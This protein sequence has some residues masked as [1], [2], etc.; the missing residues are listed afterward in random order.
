MDGLLALI[1]L[2]LFA[3]PL[4][5]RRKGSDDNER[6]YQLLKLTSRSFASVIEQLHP[7]MRDAVMIFYVVLRGLDTIE[8]DTGLDNNVKLPLLGSFR[9]V[10]K[11]KDWTFDDISP[12]EKDG[13]VLREFDVVLR[14]FH[15]LKS[16]YQ[17]VIADIADRMGKGMAEYA[18]KESQHN[19][20]GV[21]TIAD[22]DLY[23]HHVAGIVGE[24]LTRM[25]LIAGFADRSLAKTPQLYESM[26][27]FLQKTNIIRDYREDLDDGRSFWPQEVWKKYAK[28]LREF[29]KAENTDQ[30]LF[31]ISGL[32]VHS[33]RHVTDVLEYLSKVHDE[34]LFR[35]CAIPQV[36]SIA[37]L[38]LVFNNPQVFQKN[39][40]ISK[41]LTAELILG[42]KEMPSVY[43]IFRHFVREIHRRNNPQDP[44]FITVEKLCGKIEQYINVKDESSVEF[45]RH[46]DAMRTQNQVD[47]DFEAVMVP[48]VAVV[49]LLSVCG[50]M[51]FI[52]WLFGAQYP[53][54]LEEFY[55][56]YLFFI[57]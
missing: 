7:D 11:R 13:V 34:S 48:V 54:P 53:N 49:F 14:Q 28:D 35:F 56:L 9:D 12:S 30:G 18:A 39:V 43:K 17:D 44:N 5:P 23:C 6:C 52:G 38:E 40:K 46:K 15:E 2:K 41:G 3:Q 36:M 22:Y 10:L 25:A 8:D 4:H 33:L 26:G 45:A 32:V 20:D 37:T 24:G 51:M 27:L 31:C 16:E 29:L 57:S 42:S 55:N 47:I 19:Y 1:R 21:K 50:L